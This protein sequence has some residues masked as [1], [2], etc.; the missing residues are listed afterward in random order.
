MNEPKTYASF[1]EEVWDVL[2]RI[3]II[4]HIDVIKSKGKRPD[5]SYLSW[6]RAWTLTKR[7]FPASTYSH[8]SDLIHSDGTVEVEVDVI[9]SRDATENQFTNARL[10]VMDHFFNPIPNPTARQVNDSRQRALVKALAFAGLGL[11]LWGDSMIPVGTLD[12]PITAAQHELLSDLIEK[13]ETDIP[14]FLD[15]CQCDDLLE[16]PFE[17]FGSA[18]G[19]LEAK[20]ARIQRDKAAEKPKGGGTG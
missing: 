9:I 20:Y 8:R 19:L 14:K 12:D 1:S 13:T 5:I 11:N 6:S 18:K 3:D 7:K 2:S 15:W 10:G 16:L 4:D 17:K